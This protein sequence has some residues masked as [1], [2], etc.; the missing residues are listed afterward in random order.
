MK[1]IIGI[2]ILFVLVSKIPVTAQVAINTDGSQ[3]NASAILDLKSTSLGLLI[4]R[5]STIQ[6][7]AISVPADGLMVYDTDTKTVWV[8]QAATVGLGAWIQTAYG[9]GGGGLTLPD[10][11]TLSSNLTLLSLTNSGAGGALQGIASGT[12]SAILASNTNASNVSNALS[13]TSLSEGSI[14]PQPGQCR[15]FPC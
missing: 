15:E 6:R 8:F 1:K 10:S 9:S 5:M 14:Y 2:L 12:G 7:T 3:P 4:P 11:V 13:V